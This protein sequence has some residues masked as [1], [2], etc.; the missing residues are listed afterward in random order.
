[1]LV[2]QDVCHSGYTGYNIANARASFIPQISVLIM[3][4]AHLWVFVELNKSFLKSENNNIRDFWTLRWLMKN[5]LVWATKTITGTGLHNNNQENG[6]VGDILVHVSVFA[7]IYRLYNIIYSYMF[8]YIYRLLF[9]PT[10]WSRCD[11]NYLI[12]LNL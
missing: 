2:H 4:I 12:I 3:C 6:I 10:P 8:T 9:N 11:E 7:A 1:M 5:L